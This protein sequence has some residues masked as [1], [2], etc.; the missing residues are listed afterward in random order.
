[1]ASNNTLTSILT[2]ILARGMMCLRPEV[3]MTRLVNTDYS[4]EAKKKG[5][6]IDIPLSSA[7]TAEDV[8]PAATVTVPPGQES[9]TAQIALD[10]WKHTDFALSD[11]EVGRIRADQDFIP[12]QMEEAFKALAKEINDSVF[13]TYP[14]IYGY[15]GTAGI[16][17]F[18]S[19]VEVASA[20][21]L[22]KTLL[23][24][25]CPRE[26]RRGILDYAAEAAALNLAPFSDAEKRGSAGT[27]STGNLGQIFGFDWYGEDGVPTHTAGTAATIAT[28]AD[29]YD[30]G[31]KSIT[32]TYGTEGT[33]LRE[34]DI[35]TIAGDDQTYV[36]SADAESAG[37][38]TFTP[39]L[40]VAIVG[41]T[42]IT[43]KASH[44]VNLGFH[45][46][47]F[48]LAMRS[49]DAGIKELLGQRIAGNV[50]ESVVL[51]DPVSKL[52][53]RLELIRGYKMTIW[54]VD[55]LWGTALVS[56]ER[57]CRLAG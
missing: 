39:A 3:L 21:N 11:L 13:A 5:Q 6:T 47:A 22:R 40:K 8:A 57:A 50:L 33:G 9:T 24:Q 54:D 10:N 35:F 41:A 49:P 18:G 26:N 15:V 36:V 51:Q 2:Q 38:V 37:A 43:L 29:G 7:Q 30:V 55:C 1:M 25:Y 20:T 56:P 19:G 12:L 53:M 16:T 14:G 52:I 31:V 48:G 46:D 42:E 28:N 34:G 17:P 23:E 27:K 45:R 44:V 4:L 32:M